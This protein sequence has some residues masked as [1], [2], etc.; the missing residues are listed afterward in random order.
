MES[1][2][3][4]PPKRPLIKRIFISPD[5]MRL[6]AGWRLLLQSLLLI[7]IGATIYAALLLGVQF[8][9]LPPTPIIQTLINGLLSLISITASIFIA[10][11]L[12]DRLLGRW[13]SSRYGR[14]R[15]KANGSDG[16]R[17][18]VVDGHHHGRLAIACEPCVNRKQ[19]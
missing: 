10:R 1:I 5:E 7:S 15:G 8:I 16:R 13:R 3:P 4:T 12:F 18:V 17:V 14:L 19:V 2:E 6:R 9:P 11:R